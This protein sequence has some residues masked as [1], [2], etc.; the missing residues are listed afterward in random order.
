MKTKNFITEKGLEML[1]QRLQEKLQKLKHLREEKAHAY[2]ASG[3]GWHDNPGWIQIGQQEDQLVSE[4]NALQ[5]SISNAVIIQKPSN[6]DHNVRIGTTISFS[7]TNPKTG[8][9]KVQTVTIG[10]VGESDLSRN[11]ISYDS[12]I[13]N[14]MV[15]M[16]EGQE[17]EIQLPAG[18]IKLRI[19]E[20]HHE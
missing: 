4:I 14:A 11:I 20:I 9:F 12:P 13:G 10:G 18:K 7:I 1:T 5:K 17:K 8:A 16:V 2:H 6:S 3:D 19:K 15:G